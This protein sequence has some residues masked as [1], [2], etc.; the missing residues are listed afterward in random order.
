LRILRIVRGKF[1]IS[2]NKLRYNWLMAPSSGLHDTAKEAE[3]VLI[4]MLRA[5][6]APTRLSDAVAASNRVAQQCKEALRRSHPEL[7]EQEINLRFIE[8]NYGREIAG[9]VRAYLGNK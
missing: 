6:P 4:R 9:E 2:K 7:S 8:I 5:K 1:K 3:S